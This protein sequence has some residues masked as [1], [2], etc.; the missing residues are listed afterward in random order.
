[1][2]LC[3]LS[4]GRIATITHYGY[5]HV[6]TLGDMTLHPQFMT[7]IDMN[8]GSPIHLV[9]DN[10][11]VIEG[12]KHINIIYGTSVSLKGHTSSISCIF[13]LS[14]GRLISG[15]H[16]NTIKIRKDNICER[17]LYTR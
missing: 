9:V 4:D 13:Q 6:F 10:R 15:S 14:D 2:Y 12:E 17:T 7:K 11:I 5:L 16:D 3:R 1:M 8:R